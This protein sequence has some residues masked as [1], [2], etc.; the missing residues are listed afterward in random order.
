MLVEKLNWT[1]QAAPARMMRR[2]RK[3]RYEGTCKNGKRVRI[4]S[5][6][7]NWELYMAQKFIGKWPLK[8][9]A[10][11]KANALLTS[12]KCDEDKR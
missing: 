12:E 2:L 8:R 9:T 6:D 4:D 5:V 11:Q 3:G 10:L 7:G 1:V